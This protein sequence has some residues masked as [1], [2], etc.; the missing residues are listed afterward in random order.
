[1]RAEEVK[2]LVNN[3]A[4]VSEVLFGDE[5]RVDLER[6]AVMGHSF[7]G[8]TAINACLDNEKVKAVVALDPWFSPV[9]D[10]VA[11]KKY[12]LKSKNPSTLIVNT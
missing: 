4:Q 1:M 12:K 8:I 3:L 6:V 7:G 5:S 2:L 10:Q 9:G 11:A